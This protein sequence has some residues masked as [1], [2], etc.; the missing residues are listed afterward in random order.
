MVTQKK[1]TKA[2]AKKNTN[3]GKKAA[4]PAKKQDAGKPAAAK[5]KK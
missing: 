2:T 4:A 3:T 5:P 1:D